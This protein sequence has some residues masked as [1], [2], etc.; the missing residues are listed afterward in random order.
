V[1]DRPDAHELAG[2]VAR[3]LMEEVRPAVPRELRFQVLVAANAC[4]ILAREIDAGDDPVIFEAQRL[5]ALID[6]DADPQAIAEEVDRRPGRFA[7][8]DELLALQEQVSAAIR[9]G[10]FDDRWEEAVEVLRESVRAKLEVAHP[11]YDGVADDGR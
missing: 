4:A 5:L 8:R 10:D 6:P 7:D 11:G 1:Q 9:R 3:F 2:V